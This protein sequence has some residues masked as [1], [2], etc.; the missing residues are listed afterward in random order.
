VRYGDKITTRLRA[1]ADRRLRT[2]ALV[3]GARITHVINDALDAALPGMDDIAAMVAQA[4]AAA[5][6]E[7]ATDGDAR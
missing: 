6:G 3:R 2:F 7:E 1:D 5:A 4:V